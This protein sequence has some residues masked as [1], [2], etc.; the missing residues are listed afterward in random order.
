MYLDR[1][2]TNEGHDD[3][4]YIDRQLKLQKFGDWVVDIPTPHYC[5][6]NTTEVVVSE[7]NIRGF[8]GNVCSSD[9]HCKANIGLLQSWSII[10]SITSY[11]HYF[12]IRI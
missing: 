5:F 1:T 2:S 6:N 12:T 3:S 9:P 7:D 4:H 11:G 10:G 8:F